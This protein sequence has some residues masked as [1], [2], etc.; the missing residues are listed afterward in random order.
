MLRV[1]VFPVFLTLLS[2]ASLFMVICS[3][4][5]CTVEVSIK[6]SVFS[7]NRAA[8]QDFALCLGAWSLHGF[9]CYAFFFQMYDVV[10]RVVY[11][12][13]SLFS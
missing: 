5:L 4:N 13:I 1:V 7:R 12:L 10:H 3:F 2:I 9:F 6:F 8:S 11:F